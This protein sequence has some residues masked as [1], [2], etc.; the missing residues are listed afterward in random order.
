MVSVTSFMRRLF[1]HEPQPH[2]AGW[3]RGL[4]LRCSHSDSVLA[5]LPHTAPPNFASLRDF[6]SS[7]FSFD[8]GIQFTPPP[9]RQPWFSSTKNRLAKNR[10]ADR[11]F[12][13]I[14]CKQTSYNQNHRCRRWKLVEWIGYPDLL[15]MQWIIFGMSVRQMSSSLFIWIT[16]NSNSIRPVRNHGGISKMWAQCNKIFY[17]LQ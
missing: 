3:H 5:G 13:A 16:L 8:L 6:H 12:V 15:K 17:K 1:A 9:F 14:Y 7:R 4:L 2:F 11:F 10:V